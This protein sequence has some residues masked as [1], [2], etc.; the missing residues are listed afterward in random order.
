MLFRSQATQNLVGPM[1]PSSSSSL[2]QWASVLPN[3]TVANIVSTSGNNSVS[4]TL[5]VDDGSTILYD[6]NGNQ[7]TSTSIEGQN[8][9]S[10]SAMSQDGYAV[11]ASPLAP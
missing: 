8:A 9:F 6:G 11:F 10:M 4:L 3:G 2:S 5:L 7:L 1:N